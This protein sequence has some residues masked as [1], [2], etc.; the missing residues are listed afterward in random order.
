MEIIGEARLDRLQAIFA[1]MGGNPFEYYPADMIATIPGI[2]WKQGIMQG[3]DFNKLTEGQRYLMEEIC[4]LR[5]AVSEAKNHINQARNHLTGN[6]D[7]TAVEAFE[8]R[9]N[10]EPPCFEYGSGSGNYVS[11][12]VSRNGILYFVARLPN[13]REQLIPIAVNA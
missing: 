2:K 13:Y 9:K 1:A 7:R 11:N 5:R 12:L 8:E 10:F 4:V 3:V 6:Y